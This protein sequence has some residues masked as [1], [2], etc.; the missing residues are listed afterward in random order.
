M[1]YITQ[2]IQGGLG[3]GRYEEN[4]S[5]FMGMEIIKKDR[6][7]QGVSMGANGFEDKIKSIGISH[8]RTRT[9][10]VPLTE[11]E[12]SILRTELGKLTWIA[13]IDRP[14]L[15]YEVFDSAQISPKGEIIDM[16]TEKKISKEENE[17]EE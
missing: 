9:P 1:E 15:M 4:D 13:R 14:D 11:T 17:E 16:E 2:R 12:L 10:N 5:V 7:T 8:E 3:V 6:N